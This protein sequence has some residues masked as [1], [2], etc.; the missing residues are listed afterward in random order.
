MSGWGGTSGPDGDCKTF[1][2]KPDVAME[3]HLEGFGSVFLH[4]IKSVNET[5]GG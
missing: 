3:W 5:K 2:F 4:E 1:Y